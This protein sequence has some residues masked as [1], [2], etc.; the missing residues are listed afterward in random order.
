M[1]LLNTYIKYS[2]QH[3]KFTYAIKTLD[4]GIK[5]NVIVVSYWQILHLTFQKQIEK[6]AAFVIRQQ[7]QIV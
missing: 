4:N 2:L 6:K 1:F 5:I 3:I 7:L